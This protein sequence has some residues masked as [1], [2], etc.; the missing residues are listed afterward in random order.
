MSYRFTGVYLGRT[1]FA[2]AL[3][4][5]TAF[6]SGNRA[7]IGRAIAASGAAIDGT[8][9]HFQDIIFSG[10]VLTTANDA[11]ALVRFSGATQAEVLENSSVEFAAGSSGLPHA[12][13]ITGAILTR[14]DH[15]GVLVETSQYQIEPKG[16]Q[17][18]TFLVERLPGKATYVATLRGGIFIIDR[19]TGRR[20]SLGEGHYALAAAGGP[21]PQQ[22]EQNKQAP[23]VP[24]G[25]APPPV[26][27]PPPPA[28]PAPPPKPARTAWHI[29]SLSPAASVALLA[30]AAGGAVGIGV[31]VSGGGGKA[32]SPSSP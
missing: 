32:A 21:G 18:T 15:K 1:V 22:Q 26:T 19:A 4:F 5:S 28:K 17:R 20:F 7:V 11:R 14:A 29:G 8:S 13:I 27:P 30:A 24:A 6:A 3:A 9:I 16:Q 12:R 31:A 23:G 25:Q 2:A 10:N